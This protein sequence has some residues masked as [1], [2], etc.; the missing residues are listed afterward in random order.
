[1]KKVLLLLFVYFLGFGMLSAQGMKYFE[2]EKTSNDNM[3]RLV[4]PDFPELVGSSG[5]YVENYNCDIL[6]DKI[7]SS[8]SD[9]CQKM[10]GIQIK[11]VEGWSSSL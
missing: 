1:M 3:L 8:L 5:Y 9:Y 6:F 7:R 10:I 4:P 2:V 11:K